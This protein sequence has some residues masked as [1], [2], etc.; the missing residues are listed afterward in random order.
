MSAPWPPYPS[1]TATGNRIS[2]AG[3][4][5]QAHRTLYKLPANIPLA[6]A[7]GPS[8]GV[9][10]RGPLLM[11]LSAFLFA[12]L[13]ILIKV[14]GPPFRVWDIAVY[15]FV[16]GM[17]ILLAI[18]GW[19]GNPFRGSDPRLLVIRGII[20]CLSFLT[21]VK[22][23]QLIP[24]SA[25]LVLF[26]SFP[27]FAAFFAALL[28]KERISNVEA[29][30]IAGTLLGVAVLLDFSID[31]HF[32]GQLMALLS[33]AFAGLAVCV[34]KKLRET[35]GPIV[36]YL[37]F[38]L[39]GTIISLPPFLVEPHIPKTH[40]QWLI[41]SGIIFSSLIAQLIMN[42]GFQYCRSWEGGLFLSGEVIF[43]SFF[44]FVF[45]GEM[46]SWRFWLGGGLILVSIAALNWSNARNTSFS[47]LPVS[48][49]P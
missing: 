10:L 23:L 9:H 41:V 22:A 19:R 39:L 15:R 48:G 27:A 35:N 37:Y 6:K 16:F 44:G 2:R 43:T 28:Y 7:T 14:L 47:Y 4:T 12:V 1:F 18:F 42:Q 8:A 24:I 13:D 17:T 25:A 30:C 32:A 11:L 3:P 46:A 40:Y 49:P 36:I 31:A 33:A 26:Y 29:A 45:L 34:I 5:P 20:G 21:L 38:C